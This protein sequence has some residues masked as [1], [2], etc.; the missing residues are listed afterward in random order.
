MVSTESEIP[1]SKLEL[2]PNFMISHD[3]PASSPQG[4]PTPGAEPAHN[5]E[6]FFTDV[7]VIVPGFA[8]GKQYIVHD[9]DKPQNREVLEHEIPDEI[10]IL[11]DAYAKYLNRGKPTIDSAIADITS[12]MKHI[13]RTRDWGSFV[14]EFIPEVVTHSELVADTSFFDDLQPYR[15]LLVE[16]D[17]GPEVLE[18]FKQVV[19]E[20]LTILLDLWKEQ[21][22]DSP[23]QQKEDTTASTGAF[24]NYEHLHNV[25]VASIIYSAI[26]QARSLVQ[27]GN[28]ASWS[29]WTIFSK[30]AEQM[31]A[32]GEEE[33]TGITQLEDSDPGLAQ[34]AR[35]AAERQFSMIPL[36]TC[37]RA[38]ILKEILAF[39]KEFPREPVVVVGSQI[40]QPSV[41]H[42]NTD[43]ITG[44]AGQMGPRNHLTIKARGTTGTPVLY[45]NDQQIEQLKKLPPDTRLILDGEN[46]LIIANPL[47]T[48]VT[49]YGDKLGKRRRI[50]T[51]PVHA[52]T[53]DGVEIEIAMNVAD[54]GPEILEVLE[55]T[56]CNIGLART[57]Y[58]FSDG[59]NTSI[60]NQSRIYH[61]LYR[62]TAH[63]ER[64]PI[65]RRFDYTASDKL[66]MRPKNAP[67]VGDDLGLTRHHLSSDQSQN[68]LFAIIQEGVA[69]GRGTRILFPMINTA[70]EMQIEA[71]TIFDNI[72]DNFEV[73]PTSS[74]ILFGPQIE[75]PQGVE[76][77]TAIL[78]ETY[79]NI[80]FIAVGTNDLSERVGIS[81]SGKYEGRS[82]GESDH[83]NPEFLS[84]LAAISI[85]V[86]EHNQLHQNEDG[87]EAVYAE[88]CGDMASQVELLP[89]LLG[90]GFTTLSTEPLQAHAVADACGKLSLERCK[91]FVADLLDNA[92]SSDEVRTRLH[93]F[94]RSHDLADAIL[95]A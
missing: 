30:K 10:K 87:F 23:A 58:I 86:E 29:V 81:Q 54:V 61:D 24:D 36:A 75:S 39:D 35:D 11:E 65:I 42:I 74:N 33:L 53:A 93:D 63:S 94:L 43:L 82:K 83:Y 31:Q 59:A 5:R 3:S 64:P 49:A 17:D 92:G 91:E 1:A 71:S 95:A 34:Q 84:A 55:Q 32:F 12:L 88:I 8:M 21:L 50:D 76:N 9:V 77:L 67:L 89:V 25:H 68:Q 56:Q 78:E 52:V 57:E 37:A 6:I 27:D 38:E 60:Y 16:P 22:A 51:R 47:P 46:G 62:A 15:G 72:L 14:N 80:R 13:E 69:D 2:G 28:A 44:F 79:P 18:L 20:E 90:L 7:R 70:H 85:Q 26:R 66:G 45:P 48:T 41:K 73:R 4:D 40:E 19:A